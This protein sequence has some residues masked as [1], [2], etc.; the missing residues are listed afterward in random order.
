MERGTSFS[1][2]AGI[3]SVGVDRPAAGTFSDGVA[4]RAAVGRSF[5]IA[6][7]SVGRRVIS[8]GDRPA[9]AGDDVPGAAPKDNIAV[10]G[11]PA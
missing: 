9:A 6:P 1:A 4:G 2:A 10:A 5:G 7:P 11:P 3:L 8:H